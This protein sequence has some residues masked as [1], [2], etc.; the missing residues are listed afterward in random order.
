MNLYK[1]YKN[2]VNKKKCFLVF[3]IM[4]YCWEQNFIVYLSD[5]YVVAVRF[6]CK[7]ILLILWSIRFD[8]K[9]IIL[10][11]LSTGFDCKTILLILLLTRFDCFTFLHFEELVS[12]GMDRRRCRLSRCL[13][14]VGGTLCQSQISLPKHSN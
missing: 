4:S 8:C 12:K 7:T 14:L 6:Y 9:T 5:V 2:V 10:I 1:S 13:V 11:L 3:L